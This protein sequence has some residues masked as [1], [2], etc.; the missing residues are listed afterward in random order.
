MCRNNIC[1]N[2]SLVKKVLCSIDGCSGMRLLL[3]GVLQVK[4]PLGVVGGLAVQV[5]QRWRPFETPGSVILSQQN[6]A[7]RL[8]LADFEHKL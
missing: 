3:L 1:Q 8:D 7:V 4:S 2:Y 6:H 5:G